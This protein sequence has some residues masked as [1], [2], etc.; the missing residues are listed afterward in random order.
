MTNSILNLYPNSFLYYG[1]M[2]TGV[3]WSTEFCQKCKFNCLYIFLA[4]CTKYIAVLLSS[5]VF[6]GYLDC[7]SHTTFGSD[8]L[9]I[10]PMQKSNDTQDVH[11]YVRASSNVEVRLYQSPGALFPCFTVR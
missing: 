5:F 11:F 4:L 8:F 6:L 10:W 7:E 9:R 1:I 2:G 3:L